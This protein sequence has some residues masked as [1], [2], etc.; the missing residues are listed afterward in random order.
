MKSIEVVRREIVHTSEVMPSVSGS[1][2]Y[3]AEVIAWADAHPVV[4]KIV[5]ANKS[6]PFGK[7][8][9][10]YMGCI[11]GRDDPVSVLDRVATFK[12]ELERYQGQECPAEFFSWRAQ[13]TLD[14]Y[15]KKGFRGGFFRQYD[16]RYS[17]GCAS[18]DYTP[19][20][21]ETVIDRFLQWCGS[22][23]ETYHVTIDDVVVRRVR[24]GHGS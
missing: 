10:T 14:H 13:F 20:T 16:E 9:C 2:A 21:R 4:W 22:S 5:T 6:A 11:Q 17:R 1:S 15:G 3:D 12:Y 18:L 8:S 7:K 19:D 23:Y 24:E